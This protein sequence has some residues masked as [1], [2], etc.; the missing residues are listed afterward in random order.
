MSKSAGQNTVLSLLLACLIA[1][2]MVYNIQVARVVQFDDQLRELRQQ[3]TAIIEENK[4]I[5][6]ARELIRDPQLIR[7][8][9]ERDL[10]YRLLESSSIFYLESEE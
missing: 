3:Q 5:M 4:R 8:I 6:A 1:L 9:A 2:V 7:E 10:G